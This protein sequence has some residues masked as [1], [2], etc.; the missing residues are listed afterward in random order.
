MLQSTNGV[1]YQT[2]LPAMDKD[3]AQRFDQNSRKRWM[4]DKI[5]AFKQSLGENENKP[6]PDYA[7]NKEPGYTLENLLP[8]D[9]FR[10]ALLRAVR[11]EVPRSVFED[12][13][14]YRLEPW[15]EWVEKM[16]VHCAKYLGW[17][18]DRLK[19]EQ[20]LEERFGGVEDDEEMTQAM[21]GIE[22]KDQASGY[23]ADVEGG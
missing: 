7:L 11:G 19:K 8:E 9:R 6:S 21:E 20:D 4:L 18:L 12:A 5:H 2:C 10:D 17:R 16:R 14:L 3:T 1:S 22:D 23:E 15:E 13:L